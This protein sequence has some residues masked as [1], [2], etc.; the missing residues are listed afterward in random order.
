MSVLDQ[1]LVELFP[2]SLDTACSSVADREGMNRVGIMVIQDKKIAVTSAG[3]N[4]ELSSLVRVGFMD[5][6][7]RAY[8]CYQ[9]I[10]FWSQIWD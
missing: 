10:A 8:H 7:S 9:M 1:Y 5:L 3:W 4:G 6:V 2:Y